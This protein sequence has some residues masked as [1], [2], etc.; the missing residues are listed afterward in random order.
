MVS[1]APSETNVDIRSDHGRANQ[2][3]SK[4]QYFDNGRD[5]PEQSLDIG[6]RRPLLDDTK[7]Q[8]QGQLEGRCYFPKRYEVLF[9]AFLG[10][11]MTYAMRVNVSVTIAV[12]TNATFTTQ[13]EGQNQTVETCWSPNSTNGDQ[14]SQDEGQFLWSSHEQELIL[15]GFNYGYTV[16]QI[17][18][19]WLTDKIGGTRVLGISMLISAVVSL[20]SPMAAE[21][22]SSYFLALRV[23]CGI[24]EAG[25]NPALGSMVARWFPP[26]DFSAAFAIAI[27]SSKFGPFIGTV[28]SGL[29]S[30]SDVLGGWPLAYYFFGGFTLL[31]VL[32]WIVRI[33]E[34]PGRHPR[35]S[36]KEKQYLSSTVISKET[37]KISIPVIAMLT[38]IPVWAMIFT[39]FGASWTN[40]VLF[41]NQ[42]IYLKH[43]QGMDIELIGVTAAIPHLMEFFCLV[44]SGMISNR[45]LDK[46]ILSVV[47]TRKLVTFIGL[48]LSSMF[49][50][51]LAFV[52]CNTALSVLFMIGAVGCNGICMSGFYVNLMDIAPRLAGSLIG[53]VNSASA[54][55]G[56]LSPYVIGVLTPNQSDIKGWQTVFFICVGINLLAC[57]IF[58]VFGSGDEQSWAREAGRNKQENK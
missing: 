1:Q 30:S 18:A 47:A 13:A 49:Y 2:T 50:L 3:F 28:L 53:L 45:L 38:S 6:E 17:P 4:G 8:V 37:E 39:S 41:T 36:A 16:A 19:G 7:E 20:L 29:V 57:L 51:L 44:L 15:A 48:T 43:V 10:A 54:L 21:L 12:M 40:Q 52:G 26:Q 31:L 22:G 25:T 24:G 14:Y 11:G 56:G 34:T 42:P 55:A 46:E 5:G 27:S 58:M 23:M 35:I 9:L 33:Y 32:V